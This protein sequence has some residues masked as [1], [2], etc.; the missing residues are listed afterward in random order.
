VSDNALY[1]L[2]TCDLLKGGGTQPHRFAERRSSM[3]VIHADEVRSGDIVEYLGTMHRV[4]H[5]DRR[6]GWAWSV[7]Y[8]NE[9]WAMALGHGLIVVHRAA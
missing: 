1:H 6:A 7:A 5:V 2:G 9:G 8:D 3:T 4:S